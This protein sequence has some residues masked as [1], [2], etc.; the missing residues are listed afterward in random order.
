MYKD[1]D[2]NGEW[3]VVHT[4]NF[5][6]NDNHKHRIFIIDDFYTNPRRTKKFCY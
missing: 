6:L 1:S 4:D 2:P 3:G 5:Q